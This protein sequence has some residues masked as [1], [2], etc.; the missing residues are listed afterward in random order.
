[1]KY[2]KTYSQIRESLKI[3]EA[4]YKKEGWLV[5]S[6]EDDTKYIVV[7]TSDVDSKSNRISEIYKNKKLADKKAAELNKKLRGI[8]E[9][10]SV[11]TSRYERSHGKKPKGRGSWAFYFDRAGGDA[12]F[13]PHSMDYKDAINWAKEQAKDAGKSIVYVGESVNESRSIPKIQKEWSKVTDDM[14]L[15]VAAWKSAEGKEKD[16]LLKKLKDLTATKK[17]LEVELNSAVGL[18]DTGLTLVGEDTL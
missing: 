11:D 6:N 1:M 18:T 17:K 8:D 3:N 9:A 13:T 10:I 12:M 15:T 5:K 16:N 2:L 14:K 7:H 4:S